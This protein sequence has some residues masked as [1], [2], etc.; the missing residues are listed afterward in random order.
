MQYSMRGYVLCSWYN[1][2]TSIIIE[3]IFRDHPTV[4]P[5]AGEVKKIDF[6]VNDVPFDLKVTHLPEGYILESRRA[7]GLKRELTLLKQFAKRNN[8]YFDKNTQTLNCF[9]IYG[10]NSKNIPLLKLKEFC[11][12]CQIIE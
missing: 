5:A 11:Q 3:D 4:L 12:I 9:K 6:F 10:L 8:V 2:W 7:D 1:H